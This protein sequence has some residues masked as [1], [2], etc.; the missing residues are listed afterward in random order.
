MNFT[1]DFMFG[2]AVPILSFSTLFV[3]NWELPGPVELFVTKCAYSYIINNCFQAGSYIL[4]I[5]RGMMDYPQTEQRLLLT[6]LHPKPEFGYNIT[7][8]VY[9]TPQNSYHTFAI[10]H[11]TNSS[12]RTVSTNMVYNLAVQ[13][14]SNTSLQS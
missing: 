11:S 3:P 9:L 6:Y 10:N 5:P 12:Y 7:I 14:W 1:D 13:N 4:G 2:S 8:F